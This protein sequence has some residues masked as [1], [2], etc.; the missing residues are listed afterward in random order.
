[1]NNATT[2]PTSFLALLRRWRRQARAVRRVIRR[3]SGRRL[4]GHRRQH[5]KGRG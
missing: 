5:P 4:G 3:R 2:D 1:M